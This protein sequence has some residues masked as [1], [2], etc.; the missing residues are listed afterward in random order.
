MRNVNTL[1]TLREMLDHKRPIV[2][3][4]AYKLADLDSECL[5]NA[6]Q[7]GGVFEHIYFSLTTLE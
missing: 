7:D 1:I 6:W 3:P 2:D 5:I 4:A